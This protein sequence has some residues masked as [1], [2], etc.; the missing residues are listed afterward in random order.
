MTKVNESDEPIVSVS[1]PLRTRSLAN[2][3]EHWAKRAKRSRNERAL[4]RLVLSRS[5]TPNPPLVVTLTRVAP[6]KLDTDN[7][8]GALKS[9]RDGVADWIGI[10]DGDSR[11]E[12]VCSQKPGGVRIY[13]VEVE[14][15]A[16]HA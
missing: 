2:M 7:L 3:R 10:D 5:Q 14:V 16:R 15:R 8:A 4:A 12:W 11:V 6:R 13:A 1:L 9:V